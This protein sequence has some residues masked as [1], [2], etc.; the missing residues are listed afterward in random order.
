MSEALVIGITKLRDGWPREEFPD[1]TIKLYADALGRLPEEHVVDAIDAM[2]ARNAFRPSI[3]EITQEAARRALDYPTAEVAWEIAESGRLRS[4]PEPVRQ[5]AE[6]VGGRWAILHGDNLATVRAQFR[7]S[8]ESLV[9]RAINEYATS[10]RPPRR[11]LPP[12][13]R[14]LMGPTMAS[15]PE[16]AHYR[17]RPIMARTIARMSGRE[18]EPPTEE[19]KRD[20]IAVLRDYDDTINGAERSEFDPLYREAERVFMEAGE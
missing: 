13:R 7:K 18:L 16:T 19:E 5:A 9:E 1:R 8:Y 15:L 6:Y 4:A 14:E 10:G 12:S 2:L 3:G 20:A 17:P 11:E